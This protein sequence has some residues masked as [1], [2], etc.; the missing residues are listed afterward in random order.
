MMD[1][2]NDVDASTTLLLSVLVPRTLQY[3]SYFTIHNDH[4]YTLMTG[5]NVT[6]FPIILNKQPLSSSTL[7]SLL[8][9]MFH[10]FR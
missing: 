9:Y 8:N 7:S 1:M 4:E 2:K 6:F 3:K 5:R 10:N